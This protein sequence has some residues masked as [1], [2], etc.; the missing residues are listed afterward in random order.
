MVNT[1]V[2]V[3][4]LLV[5][6][7]SASIF[8]PMLHT[9]T[10]MTTLYT[11]IQIQTL[12]LF[13]FPPLQNTCKNWMLQYKEKIYCRYHIK[14]MIQFQVRALRLLKTNLSFLLENIYFTCIKN[15]E[16]CKDCDIERMS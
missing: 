4:T 12:A 3:Q 5:V 6:S 13:P 2:P 15:I 10:S 11:V 9:C 7:P 14:F 16:A 1:T 8:L